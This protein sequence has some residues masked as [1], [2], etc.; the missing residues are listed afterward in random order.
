MQFRTK[1][2][3][4]TSLSL[5]VGMMLTALIGFVGV[6]NLNDTASGEL[7]TSLLETNRQS[8]ENYIRANAERTNLLLNQMVSEV[9]F[10]AGYAQTIEDNKD[11]LKPVFDAGST[12]TIFQDPLL[13]DPASG[14]LQTTDKNRVVT[15]VWPKNVNPD[16]TPQ[17]E[18]LSGIQQSS[19]LD[20]L[21]PVSMKTGIPKSRV[22]YSGPPESDFWRSLPWFD[23]AGNV[24]QQGAYPNYQNSNYWD[25][26]PR[27]GMLKYWRNWVSQPQTKAGLTSEVTVVPPYQSGTTKQVVMVLHNPIWDK[28]RQQV[29]GSIGLVVNLDQLTGLVRN[30][31][32]GTNG[33]AFLAKAD[34]SVLAIKDEGSKLLG[35]PSDSPELLQSLSR[36][37]SDSSNKAVAGLSLPKADAVSLNEVNIQG[38]VYQVYMNRLAPLNVYDKDRGI[39]PESWALGF[40]VPKDEVL[41]ISRSTEKKVDETTGSILI[42]QATATLLVLAIVIMLVFLVS[43]RLTRSL[44][45]LTG[46]ATKIQ[47]KNYDTQVELKSRD[48]FGQLGQA[49]NDMALEIKKYTQN[50]EGLVRQRTAQL[51]AANQEITTLNERL[52]TENVRMKAELEIT[53]QLQ[54]M[55][56]PR[57]Q[58]LSQIKGL[59]VAGF[60]E[61]ADEVGGDYYDVLQQNGHVK[62]GIGDVVGH[63]LESGVLMIMVQ[64]AVRTMLASNE[65]D[66]TRFLSVVNRTIYDNVQRMHSDKNLT[67][68][69]L[70]YTGGSLRVTGQHENAVVV[71]QNGEIEVIDTMDLGFPIGLEEDIEAFV[72]QMEIQ[73]QPEDVV[74]LYTDGVTEAEDL[75]RQQYGLERLCEVAKANRAKPA[76]EIKQAI[77]DDLRSHIGQQHVFDDITLLVLKQR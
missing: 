11:T 10:L 40:V 8:F 76:G 54:Q 52:K 34:S 18:V 42:T 32:V 70:D 72:S 33:F 6:N 21:F 56:L 24:A 30:L 41:A 23:L 1:L 66:P 16:G 35:L 64:T 26:E 57:E 55:I 7:E 77:I 67:L 12:L 69:L 29:R 51:E 71:R 50:L 73:L 46:A 4:L 17:P 74:V 15:M 9:Q 37:L 20:L 28:A 62:I 68:S 36:K 58:E 3:L 31:K 19:Y 59:D 13:R 14:S 48:E 2:I 44:V 53:K 60:M 25:Y 45:V 47:Q 75:D 38:K 43:R 27:Q 22:F 39:Q 65:T 49:F 5:L 63:G 61:P